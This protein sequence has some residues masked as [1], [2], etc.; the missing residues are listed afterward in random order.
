MELELKI[1]K[2]KVVDDENKSGIGSLF[3]DEKSS[4]Q[5]IQ[6]LKVKYVEM[7]RKHD[8]HQQELQKSKLDVIGQ[9]LIYD[10]Q[11]DAINGQT[12]TKL[13]S[14]VVFET[15]IKKTLF[16]SEKKYKDTQ[17]AKNM[18]EAEC[19]DLFSQQDKESQDNY[20]NKMTL[21]KGNQF[22]DLNS[23][24]YTRDSKLA[25][26]FLKENTDA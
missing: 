7:R 25:Q 16:D 1:L 23:A 6:L 22:G 14:K 12:E 20:R 8:K 11:I 24:R 13:K 2:E 26:D 10:S 19:R 9:Q 4:H 17:K 21:D 15:K 5:H 18:I 3:D